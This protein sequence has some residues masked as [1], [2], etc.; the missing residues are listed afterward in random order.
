MYQRL[1]V[2]YSSTFERFGDGWA[3][4]VN[5]DIIATGASPVTPKD[6]IDI[7]AHKDD[8]D[9]TRLGD[10]VCHWLP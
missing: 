5:D 2:G 10:N 6:K 7:G 1:E 4:I 3:T 8:I 9:G